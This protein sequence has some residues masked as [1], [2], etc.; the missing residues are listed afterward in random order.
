[1]EEGGRERDRQT[2]RQTE[3]Q[4]ERG[5]GREER[6]NSNALFDKDCSLG[7]REREIE[8]FILQRL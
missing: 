5:M 6:S 7:E 4:E 1:M 2:D 8:N 3:T